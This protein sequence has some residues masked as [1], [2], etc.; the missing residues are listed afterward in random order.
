MIY[1]HQGMIFLNVWYYDTGYS[2][3]IF[4]DGS[5]K[6]TYPDDEYSVMIYL[7][8][9][10]RMCQSKFALKFLGLE[11]WDTAPIDMAVSRDDFYYSIE[12]ASW[13]QDAAGL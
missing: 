4:P 3:I 8:E 10:E 11:Q 5:F 6:E 12:D 2:C 7:D 13:T 9:E 1:D